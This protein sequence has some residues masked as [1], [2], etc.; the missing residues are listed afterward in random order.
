MADS[1]EACT[2][3]RGLLATR[4]KMARATP[5]HDRSHFNSPMQLNYSSRKMDDQTQ[6]SIVSE[7]TQQPNIS[8]KPASAGK[9]VTG[10]FNYLGKCRDDVTAAMN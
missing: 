6:P 7:K 5:Q 4:K 10:K 2:S 1:D 3:I 9:P 8:A